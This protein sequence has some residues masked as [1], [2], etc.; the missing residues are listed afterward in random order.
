VACAA[1]LAA[2]AQLGF[3]TQVSARLAEDYAKAFGP[4]A[5][6][7]LDD[8]RGF[9]RAQA[10][11]PDLQRVNSFFN[12]VR[13]VS[14]LEH[15][16]AE[17]YWA[18]PA[19]TAASDGGDCEDFSIAKYFALKEL[20]VPVAR[21]RITYVMARRIGEPHMVLAYYPEPHAEPLV[22]DNLEDRVLPASARPDLV[23]VYSFNDDEVLI[24]R[25]AGRGA[26]LQIRAW[27]ELLE[28]LRAEAAR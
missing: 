14:D 7:R 9:V 19:Q 21:L 12:R 20:G 10:A 27:R 26:P 23:P 16:K 15:W 8:W 24:A 17:D 4:R 25:G 6:E 28:R 2:A 5:R 1:G 22:L 11:P 3:S 13:F 18:T